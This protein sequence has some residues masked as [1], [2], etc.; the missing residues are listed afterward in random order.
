MRR[1]CVFS[2]NGRKNIYRDLGKLDLY[3][4]M[5]ALVKI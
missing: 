5:G 3:P 4:H 2:G 1:I